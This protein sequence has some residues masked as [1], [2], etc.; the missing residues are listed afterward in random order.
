MLDVVSL[1][2]RV[3]LARD[4][5]ELMELDPG[6]EASEAR[7]HEL[8]R[9]VDLAYTAAVHRR[10]GDVEASVL[11]FVRLLLARAT[12]ATAELIDPIEEWC[13]RTRRAAARFVREASDENY[14]LL[15]DEA[16][17]TYPFGPGD[18]C[19]AVRALGTHSTPGAGCLSRVGFLDC[20]AARVGPDRVLRCLEI[21]LVPWLGCEARRV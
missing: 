8:I 21:H 14:A 11:Q 4:V 15:E 5:L 17:N 7:L 9:R 10:S 3:C 19:L 18:G 13:T 6:G 2:T 16:T 20:I 1:I 12:V